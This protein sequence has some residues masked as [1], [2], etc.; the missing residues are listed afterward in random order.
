[1]TGILRK[2]LNI[3]IQD[4]SKIYTTDHRYLE[5]CIQ[6]KTSLLKCEFLI[7]PNGGD[8]ELQVRF[9]E[10]AKFCHTNCFIRAENNFVGK[11]CIIAYKEP[12]LQ[13]G[14]FQINPVK[15]L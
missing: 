9:E 15:I 1:M 8:T 3:K 10:F 11:T 4:I 2:D 12:Y 6:G 14:V 13:K 5:C 7:G